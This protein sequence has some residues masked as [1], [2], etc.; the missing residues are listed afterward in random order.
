MS[1][2][3]INYKFWHPYP[4]LMILVRLQVLLSSSWF[5]MKLSSIFCKT[6]RSIF[7]INMVV[8]KLRVGLLGLIVSSSESSS[9]TNFN[10]SSYIFSYAASNI[11]FERFNIW[12]LKT[13]LFSIYYSCYKVMRLL[14]FYLSSSHYS[15]PSTFWIVI[16]LL[17]WVGLLS[18]ANLTVFALVSFY[19]LPARLIS[20]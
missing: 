6:C 7:S 8:I 19:F 2:S 1:F 4:T 18:S 12:D 11:V 15:N 14:L 17:L 5:E 3:L 16:T 13:A 10:D 9:A 20:C